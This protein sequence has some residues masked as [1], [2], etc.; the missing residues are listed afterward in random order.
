MQVAPPPSQEQLVFKS[1]TGKELKGKRI[2]YNWAG[3]GW[4]L[5]TIKRVS[6]DKSKVVKAEGERQPANFIVLYS[7]G[8]EGPHCLTLSMCGQGQNVREAE[9]WVLLEHM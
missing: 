6:A 9:R 4:W 2:M 5:G 1:G 8:S 7:D 3:I